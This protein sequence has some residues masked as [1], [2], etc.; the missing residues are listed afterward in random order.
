[1]SNKSEGCYSHVFDYIQKNVCSLHCAI[2][3]TDYE[4]AMRN[5]L[6]KMFPQSKQTSSWFHFC[7]AVKKKASTIPTFFNLIRN[8]SEAAF[9]YRQLQCLPLLKDTNIILTFEILSA[10]ANRLNKNAFAPFLNYYK[11]QWLTKVG[12]S[13]FPFHF[14]G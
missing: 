7:Q 1:M 11:K 12:S 3:V 9:I 6:K 4:R 13:M 5:A 14:Y 8:N 2:F 10:Q